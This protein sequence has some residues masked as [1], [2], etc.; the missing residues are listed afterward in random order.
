VDCEGQPVVCERDNNIKLNNEII[1]INKWEISGIPTC[2]GAVTNLVS[3][4]EYPEMINFSGTCTYIG[5]FNVN[6]L[7]DNSYVCLDLG[8]VCDFVNV[9][10]NGVDKGVVMWAPYKMDI[11]DVV[12]KGENIVKLAVTNSIANCMEHAETPSGLIGPIKIN[13][14]YD[15]T[16]KNPVLLQ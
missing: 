8:K 7:Y 16:A 4:T 13:I 14:V 2:V 1:P 3:W 15:S 6:S 11:T 9:I 5:K 12:V 10:V